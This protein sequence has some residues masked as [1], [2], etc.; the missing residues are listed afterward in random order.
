MTVLLPWFALVVTILAG[1][2]IIKRL[3]TSMVLLFA[4]LAMISFAVIC[5]VH[6]FLPK[7]V[8]PSG[9]V[10]FDIFELLRSIA[11]KQTSGIGLLIM[12]AGG[13]AA[14]MDRIGAAH[15]LV[16]VC[17]KPLDALSSPYLVLVMGYLIGQALVTVI[18]SAAGLAMLLLVALF[19]I[20]RAVGCSAAA[21]AA[22]IGTSAGMTLGPASGTANLAAQTAGL[23]PIIYFVQC[24]LPVAIPTLI[25]V[26]ICHYFVQKYYD[27]KNDDVYSDA[28]LTKKDDLRNVPAWYAILPV[29]PIA[30]MIVFSKLVYSAVKLNTISA[31][32]LVWVFT[33][34]VELIR[35][36]DFKPVLADGA[37]IFKAMGGMFSS[38]VALII[39]AEFFATGLKVTGLISA[40]I[41]HA[42]GMGLGL[43]GMTAVLTGVVGIVTFLTGSGVGAFSSFAALAP[44]VANGLGGT[45]AGLRY[46]DAVCLRY[47]PRHVSCRRRHHCSCRCSRC[48][49]DGYRPPYMDSD[50]CRHDHRPY[51]QRCLLR[52]ILM[53]TRAPC[54][55]VGES[56]EK[57]PHPR[58]NSSAVV[59]FRLCFGN[60]GCSESDR[61]QKSLP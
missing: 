58:F 56:N 50:D 6:G 34:I 33:I 36:R 44:E 35:R 37:F 46:S 48:L 30:L 5:G 45:A 49:S 1:W 61:Y 3:S 29:L 31:L 55:P 24:Q 18:P 32:L 19:P 54:G 13:Y 25:V 20:L 42:Q 41:T 9:F 52:L 21:S 51:R 38:I 40:L 59:F 28:I 23:E 12:V 2:A 4:G 39:C 43:N 60:F 26:A 15:A 22:V 53:N 47:A 10:W 27:K 57:N 8:K 14:Y 11:T 17:V 7:G 16:R